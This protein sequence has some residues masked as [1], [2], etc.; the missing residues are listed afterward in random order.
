MIE[1]MFFGRYREPGQ[2]RDYAKMM[3][4]GV[5]ATVISGAVEVA[6]TK[7]NEGNRETF[8]VLENRQEQVYQAQKPSNDVHPSIISGMSFLAGR[9]R[10][11]KFSLK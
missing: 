6:A 10:I 9:I 4:G 3:T 5:A 11:S 8:K 2:R 7:L 1:R